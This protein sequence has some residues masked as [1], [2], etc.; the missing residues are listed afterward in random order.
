MNSNVV[1][2]P[3]TATFDDFWRLYPKRVG[4]VLAKA[5]WD[6]ITGQGLDTRILDKDSGTYLHIRLQATAE[7]IIAGL[8]AYRSTLYD[9]NYRLKTEEQFLPHCATWLNQGRWE[10]G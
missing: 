4:K 5:K 2:L 3:A 7:E 10:D 6:A 8:K 9:S 1:P